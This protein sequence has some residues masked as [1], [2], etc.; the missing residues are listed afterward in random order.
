MAVVVG[1]YIYRR[2]NCTWRPFIFWIQVLL[3]L[4]FNVAFYFSNNHYGRDFFLIHCINQFNFFSGYFIMFAI[5]IVM[6]MLIEWFILNVTSLFKFFSITFFFEK[7]FHKNSIFGKREQLMFSEYFAFLL[8]CCFK[9]NRLLIRLNE[10]IKQM[11]RSLTFRNY[12]NLYRKI[13]WL[14]TDWYR[15]KKTKNGFGLVKKTTRP[16]P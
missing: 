10:W 7:N 2:K 4:W 16:W 12:K 13:E 3:L 9:K 14:Y 11:I 8:Y 6:M 15:V 1:W 5:I